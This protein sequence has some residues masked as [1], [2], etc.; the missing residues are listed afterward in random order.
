MSSNE[1][2]N[3][4]MGGELLRRWVVSLIGP[5]IVHY[6]GGVSNDCE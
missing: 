1:S 2:E 4:E 6:I 5:L 3:A